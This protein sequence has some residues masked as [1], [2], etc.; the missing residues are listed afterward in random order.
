MTSN[1]RRLRPGL[2]H[3]TAQ[4]NQVLPTIS[5]VKSVNMANKQ[6]GTRG[7]NILCI[8]GGGTR[9]LSS[10]VVLR[11][12]MHRIN[13]KHDKDKEISKPH[14]HFDM[15]AGTGT[16]GISACM[17]GRLQMPIDRVI[18]EYAKLMESVFSEKKLSGPTMYKGTKLQEGLKTM[19]RNATGND[20]E[21]IIESRGEFACK[22]VVF[23]MAKHHLNGSMP[24]MFRSYEVAANPG[25]SCPIWQ[26]LYATMAHPDL[27]KSIDIVDSLIPQ[28]FVG[29][30]LGCS[31]PLAHVLSEVKRV[32]PSR[33]VACV[34]SIGAGHGGTI[35]LPKP[36]R[37][38]L[39][40]TQ[41]IIAIKSMAADSERIAEEMEIR[42]QDTHGVYFR[43]NVD[44]GVQDMKDGCWERLGEVME[45]TTA[46][47]YK[48]VTNQRLEDVLRVSTDRRGIVATTHLDGRIV[49]PDLSASITQPTGLKRCSAPTPVYT[50]REDENMQVIK[51]ITRGNDER[52]VCVVYGLGGVGKTQLVLNAIERTK[53]EWDHVIFVDA[54]SNSTAEGDLKDFAVAKGIGSTYEN[55]IRWLGSCR[56]RWLVVFDNADTPSTNIRQYIPGGRHGR[57]MITTRLPDLTRL[58]KGPASVCHLS[59][60]SDMDGLDLFIKTAC[61]E[62]E[63]PSENEMTAAEALLKDFG[64]LALAIVQA[65]AYIAHSPGMTFTKYR[66][67]FLSQHQRMLEQYSELPISARLDDYGQTVYTTWKMCYDQLRP[68]SRPILWLMSYLHYTH[69]FEDIFRRAARRMHSR[70]DPLP[71]NE[72]ESLSRN[73]IVECLSQFLDGDGNWD[74]IKFTNVM[75]DLRSYSLIDYDRMNLSYSIHVLVQDWARSVVP[76]PPELAIECSATL[77]SLA[78]DWKQDTESLAFKR[79]LGAHVTS[80]MQHNPNIRPKNAQR[81]SQVMWCIGQRSEKEKLE[82]KAVEVFKQELGEDHPETLRC[83]NNIATAYTALGRYEA[84]KIM[85]Q[86]VDARKRILGEE[87]PSTLRC[88]SN[89]ADNYRRL[90]Q[91][92]LAE[93]MHIQ[94]L[95]ARKRLLG[96][97]HPDTL[98]SMAQLANTYWRMGRRNEAEQLDILILEVRKRVLGEEHP[99]TLSAM[100]NLAV[101]Y[102]EQGRWDEAISLWTKACSISQAHLGTEHPSTKNYL[103]RLAR[104]WRHASQLGP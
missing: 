94:V 78:I 29:G 7:L 26:A 27:F 39:L 57:I 65:G 61:T 5:I 13:S 88:M 77:V 19:I 93:Q 58:A 87:H 37:W 99:R 24:I 14:D 41:D 49:I 103:R 79:R 1:C 44:Q 3:C 50:G 60:M 35:Q 82:L 42:F 51:C 55:T 91:L 38:Q 67:L 9:G 72:L 76:R 20:T 17:L 80:L 30:E 10:L 47:L 101:T 40:R 84:E 33:E 97:E 28:S 86:V 56:E 18:E 92:D 83:M 64:C 89:L 36:S 4:A 102:S 16:G 96:E 90:G 95:R 21:M 43:F 63:R 68:E 104:A 100:S 73:H 98:H 81:F 46:Y 12:I 74:T 62:G 32:Y 23:A 69:I 48:E 85:V 71:L 70:N 31:N 22:T 75:A 66:S 59:S 25:P 8:D 52:R 34:I 45:H 54:S 6:D 15:I 11:E 2:A 53:D